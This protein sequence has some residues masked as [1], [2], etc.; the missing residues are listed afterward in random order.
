MKALA[1]QI[2]DIDGVETYG[3]VV[4]V[5]G[6]MVEVAGP[7]HAMSVGARLTIETG[8]AK[9][10]CEMVRFLGWPRARNAIRSARWRA[11]RL[12]GCRYHRRRH[13]SPVRTMA[14]PRRQRAR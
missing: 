4:S 14:G 3:R 8:S 5:R 13:H 7:I 11:P 6:L 9:I 2:V 12:P 10:P 1:E